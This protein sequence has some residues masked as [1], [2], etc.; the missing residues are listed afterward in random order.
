MSQEAVHSVILKKSGN[1]LIYK[2]P[3]DEGL[4]KLFV[5]SLSEDHLVHLF[6]EANLTDGTYTQISK[7]K[8]C[9]RELAKEIGD[10]FEN[11]EKEIKTATG[12]SSEVNGITEYKSFAD[13]SKDELSL[14][15]QTLIER[16]DFVNI[17]FR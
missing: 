9:I 11:I 10:T 16:G 8:V 5:N 7:I 2:N 3:N 4:Y 1:K 13:C 14:T 17:N 15:I 6:F 12:L